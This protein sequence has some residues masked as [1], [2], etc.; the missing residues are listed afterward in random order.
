M[1]VTA[2]APTDR[3]VRLRSNPP[4]HRRL[5][6]LLV[7]GIERKWKSKGRNE[8]RQDRGLPARFKATGKKAL[9]SGK[10]GRPRE[11]GSI[12]QGE[13]IWPAVDQS[14]K[15]WEDLRVR[16]EAASEAEGLG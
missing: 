2:R 11:A 13:A 12:R 10:L 6:S 14:C 9:D 16:G 4:H 1:E 15:S 7:L 3:N 5:Y 8:G